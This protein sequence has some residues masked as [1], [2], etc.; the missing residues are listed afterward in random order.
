MWRHDKNLLMNQAAMRITAS[1]PLWYLLSAVSWGEGWRSTKGLEPLTHPPLILSASKCYHHVD[2][3]LPVKYYRL[4]CL[5]TS[6]LSTRP[7][8]SLVSLMDAMACLLYYT[9]CLSF[10]M[11]MHLFH[12][13]LTHSPLQS[14]HIH[15]QPMHSQCFGKG[16]A[17]P[18]TVSSLI[19]FCKA[20]GKQR[21][22]EETLNRLL[23]A[24]CTL[25]A[26]WSHCK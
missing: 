22:D 18:F 25:Q 19:V 4:A 11:Y 6:A 3:S 21:A 15:F 14:P 12:K 8:S 5:H 10:F 17:P 26:E 9:V 7:N 13:A 16:P 20:A 2:I 23:E 24:L 1:L